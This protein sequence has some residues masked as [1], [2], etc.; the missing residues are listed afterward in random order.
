MQSALGAQVDTGGV[1]GVN[2]VLHDAGDLAELTANLHHDGL[3]SLLHG[4][5]RQGREHERQHRANEHTNQNRRLGQ[6]EVQ[7]LARAGLDDVHIGNKQSQSGQG[8]GADGEA[9]TGGGGGVAEGVER[10]G[11]VTDLLGQAGHL[12]D[13][14][15]VIGHGAIGVGGEGDAQRA[16]HADASDTDA[17]QTLVEAGAAAGAEEADDN[18]RADD[19]DGSGCGAQTQRDTADDDGGAA[20]L[21]RGGELLGG[22]VVIGGVVLG[23]V[24]DGAA[25][26][27]AAEDSDIHAPAVVIAAEDE[28]AQGDRDDGGEDGG[29]VSTGAQ[30]LQQAQLRGVLLG[31]D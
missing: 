9:L 8:S 28:V 4:A 19:Q 1:V 6:G 15:G 13:A 27:Q 12:G 20:G 14:A 29:G 22:L 2:L 5:H 7:H 31:L 11:A 17:V 3:G 23:E 25:A 26:D 21:G 30:A 18:S 16:Q 24:A 10:V